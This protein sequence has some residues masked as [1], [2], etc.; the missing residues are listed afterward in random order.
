MTEKFNF[1][2]EISRLLEMHNKHK[3]LS[4]ED[5]NI[6][7]IMSMESDEVFTHS[8]L[9]AELLNPDGSH[10]LGS[11]P[12][13]IFIEN[14]L[15]PDFKMNLNNARSKKEY[16]IG[17]INEDSTEGGRIDILVRDNE[18]NMIMIEN[19]IYA[20]EQHNSLT[21]YKNK[22]PDAELFYL[23]LDGKESSETEISDT[24]DK[25]YRNLSYEKNI[26]E[27]ITECAKIAFDKPMIREVLNQYIFLIKKLTNQSTNSNISTHIQEI[28]KNNL[29]ASF[30]IFS[31]FKDVSKEL[32]GKLI[33][34]IAA[35]LKNLHPEIDISVS[36]FKGDDAI[37]T[38]LNNN[39]TEVYFR[40]KDNNL[41]VITILSQSELKHKDLVN[42]FKQEQKFNNKCNYWKLL[43]NLSEE[44][45]FPENRNN[46][47]EEYSFG[48]SNVIYALTEKK[49]NANQ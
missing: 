28:I 41:S 8:A 13:Q 29:E 7:S 4:G 23:T 24:S 46:A 20:P 15:G 47:A 22:F 34:E 35:R 43:R 37:I 40:F 44:D 12:L 21:R 27:W 32:R 42:S 48:I 9:I 14:N 16:H 36:K 5:F 33:S 1:L 25:V 2:N 31:N 39:E 38:K 18:E 10:G 30:E 49:E 26:L 19:K 3:Q 17:Y 11:K 6:F 45:L